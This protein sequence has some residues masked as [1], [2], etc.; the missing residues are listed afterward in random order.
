MAK[1]K[2]FIAIKPG[3][4]QKK[5]IVD[6]IEETLKNSG[7]KIIK[8][9]T[10]HYTYEQAME[11]YNQIPERFQIPAA[12]YLSS[13]PVIGYILED[14]R[15]DDSDLSFIDYVRSVQGNTRCTEG[16]TI[17]YVVVNDPRFSEEVADVRKNFMDKEKGIDEITTNI[18]HA[19]DSPANFLRET[20]IFDA[21]AMDNE[22]E[23]N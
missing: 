15:N 19:S 7:C 18:L 22:P 17:R 4:A 21:A 14:N 3:Y 16:G 20:K 12:T 5:N 9:T 10:A 13:A 1:Q 23:N 8:K 6:Y 11:H 2:T